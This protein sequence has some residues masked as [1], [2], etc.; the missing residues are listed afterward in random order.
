MSCTDE[1]GHEE[2][3]LKT[4]A[5]I[6]KIAKDNELDPAAM[7]LAYPLTKDGISCVIAGAP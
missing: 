5:D 6:K 2:L 3:F 1:K 4:L 7:A